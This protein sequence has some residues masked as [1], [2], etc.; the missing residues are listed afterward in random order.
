M[1]QEVVNHVGKGFSGSVLD[2]GTG[3]GCIAITLALELPH[4]R[5]FATDV[6]TT[7]LSVAKN[8][9]RQLHAMVEFLQ[10]DILAEALPFPSLDIVVS[11]P[12]YI[13]EAELGTMDIQVK[14]FEPHRAL[15]VPDDDPVVFHRVLARKAGLILKPGGLLCMEINEAL[16]AM[17]AGVVRDAGYSNVIVHQDL[18]G[19]DRYVTALAS[20]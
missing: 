12:P 16:G 9:A 8:N 15:F 19:K 2:V 10:H 17:T 18:D 6:D 3:S 11:N 4:A 7:A 1:V 20:V 14:G 5:V 13:R